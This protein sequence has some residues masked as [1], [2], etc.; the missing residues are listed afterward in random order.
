MYQAPGRQFKDGLTVGRARPVRVQDND[1]QRG[2]TTPWKD[3]SNTGSTVVVLPSDRGVDKIV[4][5]YKQACR[6]TAPNHGPS[7]SAA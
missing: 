2:E 3:L 7:L 1:T 6:R 5:R 4:V